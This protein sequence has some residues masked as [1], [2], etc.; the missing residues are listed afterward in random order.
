M[1]LA[2][3]SAVGAC[4]VAIGEAGG[5]AV[6]HRFERMDR[7]QSERLAPMIAETVTEAG[8]EFG[9]IARIAVTRGPGAFTGIRLGLS[10]A[11]G[12]ALALAIPVVGF[13]TTEVLAA[14]Q[15]ARPDGM[16]LLVAI[17]SKRGDF[18]V[19]IFVDGKAWPPRSMSG[20]D[21]IALLETQGPAML[22]GDAVERL[23]AL[24]AEAGVAFHVSGGPRLPD[25][26]TIVRLCGADGFSPDLAAPEPLYLRP[27]DVSPPGRDRAR[28]PSAGSAAD[29][30][31]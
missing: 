4:S 20:E 9:S 8:L 11:R 21:I 2:L 19:Q 10:A 1:I 27:P 15:P 6:A 18:H 25:A 22:A 29:G 26:A 16:P 24:L 17:D 7:G 3:D 13:T 12:L 30:R 14:A 23:G 5:R 28:G 31:Q